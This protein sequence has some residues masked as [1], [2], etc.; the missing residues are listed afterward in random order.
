MLLKGLSNFL[1]LGD[2]VFIH[3]HIITWK[4]LPQF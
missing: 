1:N 3:H 2:N 4:D